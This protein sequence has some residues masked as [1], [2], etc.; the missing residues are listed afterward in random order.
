MRITIDLQACQAQSAERGIGRY[1][2][3]L[4]QTLAKQ[5]A[6]GE[7]KH[8]ISLLLNNNLPRGVGTVV[9]AF[10]GL[11]PRERIHV[12]NV[13]QGCAEMSPGSAWRTRAAERIRAHHV[14]LLNPDFIHI[15]SL[16]EGW[17]DDA[18]TAIGPGLTHAGIQTAVTLYDL[19][20]LMRAD[21]YLRDPRLRDWYYRKLSSLKSSDLLLGIS[22]FSAQEVASVLQLPPSQVVNISSAIDPMFLPRT[23]DPQTR[24]ALGARYGITREFVMYTGG[25]DPRKNIEGL[26]EAFSRLP[27]ALKKRYQLAI[28]CRIRPEDRARLQALAR[29]FRLKD[30]EMVLTDFVPDDDLVSLYNE[31]TLFVFPSMYEGFGLPVLEAMACGTAVIGSDNSSIPE[32]IGRPDALFN[33][34]SIEAMTTK[35]ASVLGDEAM[36]RE[37]AAHG[38]ERA[39]LFSWENSAA[40]AFDA[41][42]HTHERR[43]QASRIVVAGS[44]AR[45]EA[46][47]ASSLPRLA[48]V[49]PMPPDKS[50]IADYAS[51]L[52]RELTRYYQVDIIAATEIDDP[53]A[54]ANCQI[55][56][57]SWFEAH[58]QDYD[59]ILYQFGNSS[60]H[61]HMFDLLERFPGVVVL[62]DFF[63]SGAFHYLN[64]ISGRGVFARA[65]YASHGYPALAEYD[66]HDHLSLILKYPLNKQ[67][68][69][70][71][72]G[73][74]V[75]SRYSQEQARKWYGP[76]VGRDWAVIAHLRALA[77]VG[78]DA[79]REELGLEDDTFLTCSFGILAPT[80]Q[81]HELLQ[82][83]LASPLGSRGTGRLVFVGQN[84][85][86]SY[87][88]TLN[89]MI[90]SSGCADRITITGFASNETYKRYLAAADLAVQLRTKSRGETSGTILDCLSHG[91]PT[92][93]NANGSAAEL[94][95]QALV[96]LPDLFTVEALTASIGELAIDSA[97]R[98]T[99]A[100][101]GRQ[102]IERAHH[103]FSIGLAYRDALERFARESPQAHTH[104]II[105]DLSRIAIE[106]APSDADMASASRA[107]ALN[108]QHAARPS[109]LLVDI[110]S[111][112]KG[113][114]SR[115][116]QLE[117]SAA[118][119]KLLSWQPDGMRVELVHVV[120]GRYH[121][122]RTDAASLLGAPEGIFDDVEIDSHPGDVIIR[123]EDALQRQPLP[124][125]SLLSMRNR[126]VRVLIHVLN[127]ESHA[128][129][130]GASGAAY[131]ADTQ[132]AQSIAQTADGIS[133]SQAAA[134]TIMP[135]LD[136]PLEGGLT[137]PRLVTIE[138]SLDQQIMSLSAARSNG[139]DAAPA[140]INSTL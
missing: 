78:R 40:R 25:I 112:R 26:I 123:L 6:S 18:A 51:E 56:T 54:L 20:P 124:F 58:G 48:L 100:H 1:S 22:E 70:D 2:M 93:I 113:D 73:V 109:Q 92:I 88:Q 96:M 52:L 72:T 29:R 68:I 101:N 23:L 84:D 47:T 120:D 130:A 132:W 95:P 69:D 42:E 55:R 43:M 61:A 3:M 99:L 65:L 134:P 85:E 13:P 77:T 89:R 140:T 135:A 50:G 36:R 82:A 46:T 53:W 45:S 15:S 59:H 87:G 83:W 80:K 28:I 62:H 97:L 118:L 98:A 136:T 102:H 44:A 39:K 35:L 24:Q 94:P 138:G 76:D 114:G 63:L 66:P 117:D 34:A 7:R 106:G 81:N 60:F 133:A 74:I 8:E 12:F 139:P 79:A 122:S 67:V 10:D 86:G 129:T 27:Q 4:A 111:L 21:I 11:V 91:L 57:L 75:H 14:S 33:A 116:F 17:N 110:S 71:A 127:P 32:V 38:I 5:A 49:S 19:I 37:L 108:Q 125:F 126:G 9:R 128:Q 137:L 64:S 90:A 107:I 103:P 31:A 115:R 131:M 104:R 121:F 41:F 119:K 30:D 16:F 105:S